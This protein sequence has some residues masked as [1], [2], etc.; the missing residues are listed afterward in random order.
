MKVVCVVDDDPQVRKSLANLM[1]S[2]GYQAVCFASG[3][4]FLASD[5]C[6]RA[7]ALV[8]DWHMPGLQGGD[9]LY[10][11]KAAGVSLPVICMSADN[12]Q[13]LAEHA[14]EAGAQG[15]LGKPFSAEALLALLAQLLG[16]AR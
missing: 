16:G 2:A 11:L 8:L 3:E 6:A 15:F 14:L 5:Y 4:G 13:A 1:R 7:Q 9:V 12:S 10:R